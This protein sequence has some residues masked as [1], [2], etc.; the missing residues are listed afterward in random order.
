MHDENHNVNRNDAVRAPR[1]VTNRNA[2]G[3]L[4]DSMLPLV[5]Y[6]NGVA[7]DEDDQLNGHVHDDSEN[8]VVVASHALY[9]RPI[10]IYLSLKEI[11]IHLIFFFVW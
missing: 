11:E 9:Y 3:V 2:L 4:L 8:R 7:A 10:Y 1:S 6:E 5:H